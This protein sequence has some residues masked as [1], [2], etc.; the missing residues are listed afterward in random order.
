MSSQNVDLLF[1]WYTVQPIFCPLVLRLHWTGKKCT[2]ALNVF[3]YK[4]KILSKIVIC[5]HNNI[6]TTKAFFIHV[7]LSCHLNKPQL[8]VGICYIANEMFTVK[9][10]V[11]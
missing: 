2:F 8:V 9:M 1:A 3:V 7:T 6:V 5:V 4:L 10:N 11:Y